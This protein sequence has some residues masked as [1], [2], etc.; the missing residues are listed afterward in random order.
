MNHHDR[1]RLA[2]SARKRIGKT[3]LSRQKTQNCKQ[4]RKASTENNRPSIMDFSSPTMDDPD[5]LT[6]SPGL[7]Y[8]PVAHARDLDDQSP[9]PQR[10]AWHGNGISFPFC[11]GPGVKVTRLKRP[12]PNPYV[13]CAM[14]VIISPSNL[15]CIIYRPL[16]CRPLVV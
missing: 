7:G 9:V 16:Q 12:P 2:T 14:H 8:A 6:V 3:F 4:Q 1:F 15:F 10:Q 11:P 13:L 5:L